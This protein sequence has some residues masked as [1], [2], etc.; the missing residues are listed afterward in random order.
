MRVVSSN[1]PAAAIKFELGRQQIGAVDR[2]QRLTFFD[3]ITDGGEQ[4]DDPALVGR[5]DL[6]LHVFVEVDAADRLL[7]DREFTCFD[8]FYFHRR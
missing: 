4:G 8:R 1:T 5:K 7:L 2:E 6:R 3:V